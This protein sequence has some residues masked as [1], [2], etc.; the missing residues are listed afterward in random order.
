MRKSI[1]VASLVAV[2]ALPL[3]AAA[4]NSMAW[5]VDAAHT[6]VNFKVRHFFTPVTGTFSNYD[7]ELMFDPRCTPFDE[8]GIDLMFVVDRS[9][10]M[11]SDRY[12]E[13]TRV[14]L[15][16]FVVAMNMETS[17][18]GLITYARNDSISRNL[19]SDRDDLIRVI[20]VYLRGQGSAQ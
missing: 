5:N 8:I 2:F 13:P 9:I 16:N 18:A 19:T 1:A 3:T 4:V 10:R 12:F 20:E 6:E 14:A 11:R 15:G 7:V 17:S